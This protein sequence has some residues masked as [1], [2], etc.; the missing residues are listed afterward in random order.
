MVTVGSRV[1]AQDLFNVLETKS[2][3]KHMPK[4]DRSKIKFQLVRLKKWEKS[5]PFSF[6]S[7]ID[8]EINSGSLINLNP[9]ESYID[10]TGSSSDINKLT[11]LINKRYPFTDV[12]ILS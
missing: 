3:D 2:R 12:A 6:Y 10:F 8:D 7:F 9:T 1:C 11:S 4:N 5:E